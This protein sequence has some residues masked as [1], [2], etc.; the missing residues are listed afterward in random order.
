[1]KSNP[2]VSSSSTSKT[3][4]EPRGFFSTSRA[5]RK[6]TKFRIEADNHEEN[7]IR[8]ETRTEIHKI[9]CH[10]NNA[11]NTETLL[12]SIIYRYVKQKT[13][14][15]KNEQNGDLLQ[16]SVD[17]RTFYKIKMTTNP[18]RKLIKLK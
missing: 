12:Y 15:V 2:F 5:G 13:K 7:K 6:I 3:K 18:V 16:K 17:R 9:T 11:K 8:T 4:Q 1:M 14:A 10:K